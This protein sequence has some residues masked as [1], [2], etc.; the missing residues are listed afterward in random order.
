M[1]L[2]SKMAKKTPKSDFG[3]KKTVGKDLGSEFGFSRLN[4][5]CGKKI[6]GIGREGGGA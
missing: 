1:R 5:N 6:E 2:N 4:P 3:V